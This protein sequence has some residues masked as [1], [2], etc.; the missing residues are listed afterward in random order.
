MPCIS[1]I[2]DSSYTRRPSASNARSYQRQVV[3]AVIRRQVEPLLGLVG[4]DQ[5][6]GQAAIHLLRRAV[7]HVRVIEEGGGRLVDCEA[8]APSGAGGNRLVRTAVDLARHQQAVPVHGGVLLQ[9]VGH[10]D[11]DVVAAMNTQRRPEVVAIVAE[12]RAGSGAE[13]RAVRSGDGEAQTAL[14]ARIAQRRYRQRRR[15]PGGARPARSGQR[16]GGSGK[17][18]AAIDHLAAATI[19]SRRCA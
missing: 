9:P 8:R 12:C 19:G 1:V 13:Q 2:G 18:A 17:E 7:V 6:A 4:D 16:Q 10:L 3:D 14:R 15:L 11:R 5:H